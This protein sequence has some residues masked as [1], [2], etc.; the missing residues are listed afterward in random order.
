MMGWAPPGRDLLGAMAVT[1]IPGET[2][3]RRAARADRRRPA[4]AAKVL[5]VASNFPPVVGGSAV[6]YANIARRAQGQVIVLAPSLSYVDGGPLEGW[7]EHDQ[8]A[9]HLV[10]RR[11]LLRSPLRSGPVR[12]LGRLV[13]AGQELWLR[14]A[15]VCALGRLVIAHGVRTVCFGELVA[16]SWMIALLRFVPG[17]RT[18]AYIHGEEITTRDGYDRGRRQARRALGLADEVI[19]V[20][21]FTEQAVLDLLGPHA[22]PK[23]RLIPNGVD[24]RRF[25]P[26]D[27][28]DALRRTLGLEGAFVFVSVCRL[29]EKKGV[30]HAIRAL[31]IVAADH[32]EVRMLVVGSGPFED[33]LKELAR[34]CGVAE[35]VVFRGAAPDA[36]LVD[37]Y[38]LG[39]VFVM[40]N[41][42]L[43]NGDTEGFG[44]VFLEANACG[45]PVIAGRDG[46]STDAVQH[47]VNGLV[48]DGR[49]V[50]EIA[51][52]MMLL[53]E[54]RALRERLRDGGLV[55]AA[56]ADW[57]TR[58]EAFLDVCSGARRPKR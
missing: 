39:D 41:R 27:P 47:G 56:A 2:A 4:R 51:E 7:R 21:R 15:L 55:R 11:P 36:E 14:F 28:G 43:A 30:D 31:A 58:A 22:R 1:S 46:G 18:A 25:R 54:N 13:A 9:D 33:A 8:A 37:H 17:L 12:G 29:L 6:V 20:S 57:A 23:L 44:L 52:A 48:V 32:P 24:G 26:Q 45:L 38:G 42:A 49:S 50:D 5:L 3:G 19:V 40:P 34:S 16:M 10:V 53:R 35:K